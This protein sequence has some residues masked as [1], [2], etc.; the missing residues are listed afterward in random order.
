MLEAIMFGHD[1]V[2]KIVAVIEQLVAVAGKEKMAVKLHAVNADVNA[3]S[4]CV[5]PRA[6]W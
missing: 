3:A 1:E 5:S 6:V 2:R 4:S